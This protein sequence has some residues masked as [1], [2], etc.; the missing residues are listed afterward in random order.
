MDITSQVID[1][2]NGWL[3]NLAAHL[4]QP[5]LAAADQLLFQTPTYDSIPEVGR[6]WALVRDVTDGLFVLALLAAG[7][8]VMTSETVDSRY[9]AKALIPRI[10]LAAIA[11]NASLALCGVLI[12]L[13]NA[14]IN[15]VVGSDPGGTTFHQLAT[16]IQGPQAAD[17][18][19]GSLV[20]LAA[21]V[22]AILLVALYIGRDVVLLVATVL[23]PLALAA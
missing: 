6:A 22:L 14:L 5:A 12:K 17:Q 4:L 16:M 9:S 2:I 21:A 1:A 23:S 3:Q 15:G 19:V 20:G 11:A 10:V 8:I 18:V 7:V 13:D